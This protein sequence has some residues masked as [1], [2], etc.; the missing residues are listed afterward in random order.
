[1]IFHMKEAQVLI[2][3]ILINLLFQLSKRRTIKPNNQGEKLDSL[4]WMRHKIHNE[5]HNELLALDPPLS[6]ESHLK[7]RGTTEQKRSPKKWTSRESQL[8]YKQKLALRLWVLWSKT[9][10]LTEINI[11]KDKLKKWTLI[12][13]SDNIDN[14]KFREFFQRKWLTK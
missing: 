10:I 9:V 5:V 2:K 13:L 1:M 4:Y 6:V 3:K 8:P 14:I 11:F 12:V 7:R